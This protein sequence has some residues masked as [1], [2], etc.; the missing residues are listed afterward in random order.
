MTHAQ[1]GDHRS[2]REAQQLWRGGFAPHQGC[3]QA[4]AKLAAGSL[5][6]SAARYINKNPHKA[7]FLPTS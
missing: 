1:Q 4:A 5:V 7:G 3:R 6:M 2:D